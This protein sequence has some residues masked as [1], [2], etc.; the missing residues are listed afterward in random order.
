MIR[1]KHRPCHRPMPRRPRTFLP[2]TPVHLIQRGNNRQVSFFKEV[3]YTVYLD[4]LREAS[5]DCQVDIHSFVLM[6]NHVHL[7]CTPASKQ[8]I[9]LMMQKLGRCYVRYV[10]EAYGRTG[11]LW[12]G[13]FKASM[14]N[15]EQYLLTVSRYIELN[16]VRAGMV[17]HPA[18]YPWSSYRSNALGLNIRM[19]K[20][21][22]V[23]KALGQ[24]SS[25]REQSYRAL[26]DS[27][28]PDFTQEE[29][30]V[31]ANKS[32][33]LGDGRFKQQIER[34]LGRKLPPFPR[35]GDR[36]STKFLQS[37]GG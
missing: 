5:L 32:W 1:S 21:H 30:R 22:P 36:K 8:G 25:Q 29:I 23:Y 7:L 4:K 11:T 20:P 26:F 13:R 14:V 37:R 6:T 9:S 24:S 18:E 33:V 16:P 17:T 28:I 27:Q 35:G 2:G 34:Q 31:A 19:I 10:N 15:S 3:D 12:E